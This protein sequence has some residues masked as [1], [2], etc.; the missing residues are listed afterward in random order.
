MQIVDKRD[1][2][3]EEPISLSVTA[4]LANFEPFFF[5]CSADFFYLRRFGKRKT[6]I[7]DGLEWNGKEEGFFIE[8][9]SYFVSSPEGR[10][11]VSH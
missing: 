1:K 2:I 7:P 5:S 8:S 6:F 10:Y 11:A 4:F 3:V 9:L